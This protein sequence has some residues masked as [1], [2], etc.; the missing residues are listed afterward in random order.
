MSPVG[1]LKRGMACARL[2]ERR[3][4]VRHVAALGW[5]RQRCRGRNQCRRQYRQRA[6][7][8]PGRERQ[9]RRL[10]NRPDDRSRQAARHG[11]EIHQ[12]S[13]RRACSPL[14]SPARSTPRC[15]RSPSPRSG[16]S[17]S[18]FA[19]PY[20][21]SDQSLTVKADSGITDLAGME[22]KTVGVD[23][24]STGDMWTTGASGRDQD[25]HHQ[26]V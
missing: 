19:Q 10:R 7:G 20:Y 9:D 11:R 13:V 14:F 4:R 23:T 18:S 6:L 24:G 26:Q 21:D 17:R 8:I 3:L 25:R 15:R 2:F 5:R 1:R 22:G 16:W 12:H